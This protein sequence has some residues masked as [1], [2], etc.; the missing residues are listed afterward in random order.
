MLTIS[1]H[2]SIA[3]LSR[4]EIF[5]FEALWSS[6]TEERSQAILPQQSM[7]KTLLVSLLA[8]LE[9][10]L[11]ICSKI[12]FSAQKKPKWT[13]RLS[14]W[15]PRLATHPAAPAGFLLVLWTYSQGAWDR[16]EKPCCAQLPSGVGGKLLSCS[17]GRT[18][19]QPG[20]IDPPHHHHHRT[21]LDLDDGI[22]VHHILLKNCISMYY[23]QSESFDVTVNAVNWTRRS[24]HLYLWK[25]L[26]S[27][28]T[29]DQ[30]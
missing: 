4:V 3:T 17:M 13:N 27:L 20:P 9:H 14:V 10:V 7:K 8:I 24:K 28:P 16:N 21:S 23:L 2:P 22:Q 30:S 11:W 1:K 25:C 19:L 26:H 15:A 29:A 6:W 12:C 5:F 18:E